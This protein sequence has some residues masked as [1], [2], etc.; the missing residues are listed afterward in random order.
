MSWSHNISKITAKA[1]KILGLLRRTFASLKKLYLLGS[2][3]TYL[4]IPNLETTPTQRY[5]LNWT[6]STP[7]YK[8]II[9][10]DYSSDY[11]AR[12]IT[13]NLLPMSMLLELRDIYFFV[14]LLKLHELP[15]QSFNISEYVSF[16]QNNT[17]SGTFTK[18]DQS[19]IMHNRD[20]QLLFL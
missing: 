3:S 20:K 19:P 4:W 6:Y 16:S 15:N 5:Q 1:Y 11:R 2:I 13:L 12:L 8:Y 10:N 7:C 17:R 9:L 18:L 14:K